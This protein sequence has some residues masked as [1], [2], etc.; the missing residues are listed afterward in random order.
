MKKSERI[1][2]F[3]LKSLRKANRVYGLIKDGDQIAVGVSGGKDSQTLLHLLH[4]WQPFAPIHYGLVALHVSATSIWEGAAES[5]VE[6]EALFQSLNVPYAI[7]PLELAPD[8]PRPLNC[9]HCSWNRRRTLFATARELGCN[10][11]ALGHHADD[12]AET[13]LL[14]LFFHGRLESMAPRKEMFDGIAKTRAKPK[15]TLFP[16]T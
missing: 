5:Q 10:K 13:T 11:I 2:S 9:F 7:R 12:I 15:L 8:E 3:L 16:S 1:A 14:N 4:K 6:L